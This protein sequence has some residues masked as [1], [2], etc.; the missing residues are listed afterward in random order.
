MLATSAAKVGSLGPAS[1]RAQIF[2]RPV[3]E[4][5]LVPT[6]FP[7]SQSG[8]AEVRLVCERLGQNAFFPFHHTEF[9]S[10]APDA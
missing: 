7:H 4:R 10:Q 1:R 2:P 3:Q 5:L 8:M 9:G 6:Y